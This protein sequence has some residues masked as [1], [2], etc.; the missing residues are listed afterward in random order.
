LRIV[1]IVFSVVVSLAPR[2]VSMPQPT[3]DVPPAERQILMEFFAATGGEQW[4]KRGGWGTSTPVC[5][6][7]GVICDFLDGDASRPN[8]RSL[9]LP[10]NNLT[11]QV[12]PSLAGLARLR[13]LN[14]SHNHLTGRIAKVWLDRWDAHD[15]DLNVGGNSIADFV[16]KLSVRYASTGTL[17]SV[18]D[19]V[20]FQLDVDVAKDRSV[21]QTVRCVDYKSRRTY[22]LVREGRAPGI[23]RFSRALDALGFARFEPQ[24]E[25]VDGFTTHAVSLTTTATWPGQ[26]RVSVETYARQGPRD[27]WMAQQ[28][29]LSLLTQISWD[30]ERR[31]AR[32]DF[33]K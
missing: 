5:D 25:E 12:P 2:A 3:S 16:S 17:C 21:F 19:D 13:S 27:V 18:T 4:T 7:F 24:Y 9:S 29:F 30:R 33:Q 22:C 26:P 10:F 8:V 15:F 23:G 31:A 14:L 28:L 32:C 1:L 11:G 6:W 20:R